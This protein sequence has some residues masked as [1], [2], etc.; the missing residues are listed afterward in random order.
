MD[1][2]KQPKNNIKSKPARIG[3]FGVNVMKPLGINQGLRLVE[4]SGSKSAR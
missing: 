4:G 2:T 1:A 3:M